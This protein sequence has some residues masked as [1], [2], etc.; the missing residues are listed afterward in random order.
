[1]LMYDLWRCGS[2]NYDRLGVAGFCAMRAMSTRNDEP[3]KASR[4]FDTDRDGFVMGEGAGVLILESLEHAQKRGARIYAEVIG[5]G[6]SGRCLSYDR[7][8]SGWSST[9]YGESD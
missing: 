7:S 8:R 4:P 5:Y 1:M 9:L 2:N 6:M 3:E